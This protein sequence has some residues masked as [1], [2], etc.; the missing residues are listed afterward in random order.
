MLDG[1][2]FSDGYFIEGLPSVTY[3]LVW[4]LYGTHDYLD[5]PDYRTYSNN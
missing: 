1:S 5:E 4:V 3:V 2:Q